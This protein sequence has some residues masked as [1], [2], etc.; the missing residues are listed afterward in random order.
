MAD[1]EPTGPRRRVARRGGARGAARPALQAKLHLRLAGHGTRGCGLDVG[2]RSRAG[3][4]PARRGAG[5]RRASSRVAVHARPAPLRSRRRGGAGAR[6]TRLRARHRHA[7]TESSGGLR[8]GRSVT[9]SSWSVSA[10]RA[11]AFLEARTRR[12]G[13]GT[14]ARSA[15]A[16]WYLS[17]V[18]LRAGRWAGRL[19][20]R[21]AGVRDQS[22]NTGEPSARPSFP[23]R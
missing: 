21:R 2:G 4:V 18:E 6:R 1:F 16:L 23:L 19:R 10:D 7:A 17:F 14:S 13:T 20:I 12:S 22:V 9:C 8:A 11:R 3:R 5:R 15:A